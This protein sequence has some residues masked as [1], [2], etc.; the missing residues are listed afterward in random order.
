[1]SRVVPRVLGALVLAAVAGAQAPPAQIEVNR[2]RS[3]FECDT[4]IGV[5]WYGT[6][7][8]CLKEL[9]AG[10][11]VISTHVIDREG[12]LRRNPC[13]GRSPFELQR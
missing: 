2:P 6:A 10:E 9:C 4:P 8:R 5:S 12:R 7:D 13:Y 3:I 1:M 11:N